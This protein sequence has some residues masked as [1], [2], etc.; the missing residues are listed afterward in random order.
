MRIELD[1]WDIFG[2]ASLGL[3][4]IGIGVVYWPLIPICAGLGGLRIYYIRERNA[5]QSAPVSDDE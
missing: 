1:P 5:A 4:I 3:V 2:L